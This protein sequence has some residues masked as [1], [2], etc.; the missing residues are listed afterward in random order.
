MMTANGTAQT[1]EDDAE[2]I[3]Q[4]IDQSTGDETE[5]RAKAELSRQTE[6]T[7]TAFRI[8]IEGQHRREEL[9]P[10]FRDEYV[11]MRD[12]RRLMRMSTGGIHGFESVE[13]LVEIGQNLPIDKQTA[14]VSTAI[15]GSAANIL[16]GATNKQLR[17]RKITFIR[18]EVD[19]IMLR[20]RYRRLFSLAAWKGIS[21]DGVSVY[22]PYVRMNYSLYSTPTYSLHGLSY[23]ISRKLGFSYRLGSGRR[24]ISGIISPMRRFRVV[25][26]YYQNIQQ[27]QSS[28]ELRST[29]LVVLRLIFTNS[30][31]QHDR[32]TLRSEML[33]RL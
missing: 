15:A 30:L 11:V 25:L 13:D 8:T 2:T 7:A 1:L 21:A 16:A 19:R 26:S 20:T 3:L 12:L 24:I 6:N 33:V 10:Y 4:D 32:R 17:K 9:H 31:I 22:F 28:L 18:W 14:L 29:A 27:F 23:W 5:A